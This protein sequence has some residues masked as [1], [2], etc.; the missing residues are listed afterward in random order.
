VLDL[1]RRTDIARVSEQLA[2]SGVEPL[3]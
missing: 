3:L 1:S 2:L